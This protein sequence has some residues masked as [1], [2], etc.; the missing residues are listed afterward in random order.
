MTFRSRIKVATGTIAKISCSFIHFKFYKVQGPVDNS[1][2]PI[3]YNLSRDKYCAVSGCV[4]FSF[5]VRLMKSRFLVLIIDAV[6]A[7]LSYD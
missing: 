2:Q 3:R 1:G 7:G 6:T 5:R 4:Q